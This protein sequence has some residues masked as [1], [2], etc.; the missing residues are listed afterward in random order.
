MWVEAADHERFSLAV[1][2]IARANPMAIFCGETALL[3]HGIPTVKAPP[4]IDVATS[5]RGRLGQQPPTFHVTGDTELSARARQ[6]TPPPVRRHFH[7]QL[8]SE[9]VGEYR[10]VPIATA[11]AEVLAVGEFARALT[12]ADGVLRQEPNVPLLHR[13][14]LVTVMDSLNPGC[15]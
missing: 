10:T 15:K 6:F 5:S 2:A 4:V 11:L 13:H 9:L 7:S 3:L 1:C 14:A 8:D 12:V